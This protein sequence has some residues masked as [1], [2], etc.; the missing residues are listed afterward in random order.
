MIATELQGAVTVVCP[1]ESLAGT[2]AEDLLDAIEACEGRGQPMLVVDLSSVP[3]VNSEGL[4]SLLDAHDRIRRRGGV[5]KLA[6]PN[7]LVSE[8]L[9]AT[10]VSD[11]YETFPSVQTAV[12]SFAR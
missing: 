6:G 7:P 3:L 1:N 8:I 10:G 4:S 2:H 9:T 11:R 12:G 5:I